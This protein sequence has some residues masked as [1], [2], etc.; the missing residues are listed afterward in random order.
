MGNDHAKEKRTSGQK[1]AD[2]VTRVVG[3]WKFL[4]TQGV[5]LVAWIILNV[6]AS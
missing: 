3:S 6:I 4:I 5:I 2:E 1:A